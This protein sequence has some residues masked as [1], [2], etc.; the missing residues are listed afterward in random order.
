MRVRGTSKRIGSFQGRDQQERRTDSEAQGCKNM[1]PLPSVVSN[2]SKDS[3]TC[4]TQFDARKWRGEAE[5]PGAI[6][7]SVCAMAPAEGVNVSQILKSEIVAYLS[8]VWSIRRA[9][10]TNLTP[11]IRVY[12]AYAILRS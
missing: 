9:M 3:E 4:W 10:L 12:I 2:S 1:K 11:E 6:H 8:K 5:D 7:F